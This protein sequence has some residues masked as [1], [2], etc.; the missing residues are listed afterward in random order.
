MEWIM[1]PKLRRFSFGIAIFVT[2]WLLAGAVRYQDEQDRSKVI[3]FSH[4][5]HIEEVGAECVSCHT[6]APESQKAADNNLPTM[7]N[8]AECHDVE[9]EENCTMCHISEEVLEPF[10][11]P[12][13][14]LYFNH[15][16]HVEDQELACTQCHQGLDKVDLASPDNL[17]PMETCSRC[18]DGEKAFADCARCHTPDFV[19]LPEDHQGDWKIEHSRE[20]RFDQNRCG[21]CHATSDCQECHQGAVLV[22]GKDGVG[23]FALGVPSSA[24]SK[25]QA[26]QRVHDLNYVFTH[27]MD[28]RGKTVDCQACHE[29]TQFCTECHLNQNVLSDKKPVWHGGPDWS[30]IAGGVG[31]GGG[32]HAEL[33]RRDMETC[34]ACH[35]IEGNDPTCVL[36][37]RDPD[38]IKGTD[39]R[40]HE[41][42]FAERFGE[43]AGPHDPNSLCFVCHVDTGQRGVGFCGYCHGG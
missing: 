34:A 32:R 40:T 19:L 43:G 38:G 41:E 15:A 22:E 25:A 23:R 8:C 16:F 33:A 13:R 3:K 10:E 21:I 4:K 29:V 35:Q 12:P 42:G 2:G 18:H 7:D 6:G 37:H 30:A 11:N 36:C 20:A 27:P 24:S 1:G 14:Q 39:P 31:T 17:P 26:V 9:D 5:F 28:A